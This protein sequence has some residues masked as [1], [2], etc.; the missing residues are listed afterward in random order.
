[1]T[2]DA[3]LEKVRK[4]INLSKDSAATPGESAAAAARAQSLLFAHRLSLADVDLSAGQ[5]EPYDKHEHHVGGT[6]RKFY[7]WR[8]QLLGAIA[9]HNFC[10]M[11]ISSRANP[12]VDIVGRAADVEFVKWLFD[13]VVIQI[14]QMART[15]A[16][17]NAHPDNK[18]PSIRAFGLGAARTIGERLAAQRRVD[19][20]QTTTS[21][22]L[23][24]VTDQAVKDAITRIY[25]KT[26]K[27]AG[28]RTG[29]H[30]AFVS[31]AK[32]GRTIGLNRPMGA[33]TTSRG[34]IGG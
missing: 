24:L 34:A 2:R 14:D 27:V 11:I 10:R 22:A 4:L 29:G 15:W 23:V 12:R 8:Q 6:N 3:I 1:M 18:D 28:P 33:G 21:Q 19:E 9:R 16:A 7:G 32:A 26:H 25:G 17:A 31:G 13:S 5:K 30:N 20:S